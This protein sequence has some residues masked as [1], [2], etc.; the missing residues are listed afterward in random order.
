MAI[1]IRNGLVLAGSPPALNRTD[2]LV[3]GERIASVGPAVAAPAGAREIDASSRIVVP[4]MANAHTHAASHLARGRAGNWT[5]EDLLNHTAA[6][7]TC[8]S[9]EDEYLSA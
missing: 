9:P 3:E 6:N 8:R 4:G 7:Y 1:V 2:V 5:L